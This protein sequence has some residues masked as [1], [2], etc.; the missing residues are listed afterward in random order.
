MRDI[1]MVRLIEKRGSTVVVSA[2][3]IREAKQY[4]KNKKSLS[5]SGVTNLTRNWSAKRRRTIFGTS[6]SVY[7][8]DKK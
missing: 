8:I 7:A 3:N 1:T 4:A 2:S 5:A 6:K